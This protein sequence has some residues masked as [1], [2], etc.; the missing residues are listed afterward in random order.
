MSKV[1]LAVWRR[2]DRAVPCISSTHDK[3]LMLCASPGRH[4]TYLASRV[5]VGQR[6]D[7][8]YYIHVDDT[9]TI[10]TTSKEPV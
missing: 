10:Q 1:D 2:P 4:E 6:L 3:V 5:E 7:H 8:F 9:G